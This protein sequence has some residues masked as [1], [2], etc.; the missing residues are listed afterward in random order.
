MGD[1]GRWGKGTMGRHCECPTPYSYSQAAF[2]SE[3]E[4]S[5]GRGESIRTATGSLVFLARGGSKLGREGWA[6]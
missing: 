3:A 5:Q 4:V 2:T 1:S 6:R